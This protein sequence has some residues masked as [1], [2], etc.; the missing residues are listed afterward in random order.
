MCKEQDF[1]YNDDGLTVASDEIKCN[2][3]CCDH[4]GESDISCGCHNTKIEPH[5]FEI[6][7]DEGGTVKRIK[8]DEMVVGGGLWLFYLQNELVASA[9]IHFIVAREN[10]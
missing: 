5:M 3:N 1:S 10:I 8:A 9:P 2:T 4:V 6:I 7:D